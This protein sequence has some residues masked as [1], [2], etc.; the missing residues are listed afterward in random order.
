MGHAGTVVNSCL[1][2]SP[3]FCLLPITRFV[4]ISPSHGTDLSLAN[5][6]RFHCEILCSVGLPL[7]NSSCTNESLLPSQQ[8]AYLLVLIFFTWMAKKMRKESCSRMQHWSER[9]Y[10]YNAITIAPQYPTYTY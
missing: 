8:H 9:D 7:Y 2:K 5:L 1:S 3:K 6:A 4:P 10:G